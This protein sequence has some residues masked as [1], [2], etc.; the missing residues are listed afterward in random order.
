[1]NERARRK[2]RIVMVALF[3]VVFGMVGVSFAAV[4]LY[5]MFCRVTGYG[6][7][8]QRAEGPAGRILDRV[9]KVRFNADVN[10]AMPWNFHPEVREVELR[11]GEQ[12]MVAYRAEN[13][14]RVPVTGTATFN[15]T[16]EKAGI[17]FN[18]IQ[19]FCFTEQRLEPGQAVDMPVSFFVDPA[20]ADDRNLDDV[21]T[22]TLS[23]TF[24][25]ARTDAPPTA[26]VNGTARSP[27][28][29]TAVN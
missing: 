15:V 29:A 11:L 12:G 1:M 4:P 19:C 10:G 24:F 7:T 6:G 23:Y 5:Q 22:I 16:P 14:A 25:R 9:V 20:L 21:H 17:Y 8:T 3:G 2:N 26:A 18:K 27:A 28:D 13:R